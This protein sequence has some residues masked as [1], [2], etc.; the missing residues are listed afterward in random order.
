MSW[1]RTFGI[2]YNLFR[3]T[4][5]AQR[6]YN[7]QVYHDSSITKLRERA[8]QLQLSEKR[9]KTFAPALDHFMLTRFGW[10]HRKANSAG[11][12]RRNLNSR[13]A[14]LSSRSSYV[15][16]RD[17]RTLGIYFPHMRLRYRFAPVDM[18]INLRAQRGL[19]PS[20]IG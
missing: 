5:V 4:R 6:W 15:N 16:P 3:L 17:Y 10:E 11:E 14:R 8:K 9:P 2:G 13:A 19:L 1:L 20:F 18:N 12:R 7:P